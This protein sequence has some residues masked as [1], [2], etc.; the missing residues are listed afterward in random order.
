MLAGFNLGDLR[1][2]QGHISLGFGPGIQSPIQL[3]QVEGH[4]QVV[5]LDLGNLKLDKAPLKRMRLH[6]QLYSGFLRL[7][8]CEPLLR[9]NLIVLKGDKLASGK[10][11]VVESSIKHFLKESTDHRVIY[12]CLNDLRADQILKQTGLTEDERSRLAVISAD[13]YTTSDSEQYLAPM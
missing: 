5:D 6:K 4:T 8:L 3:R 10:D 13:E 9:G 7:D 1:L 11:L 12:A 2:S